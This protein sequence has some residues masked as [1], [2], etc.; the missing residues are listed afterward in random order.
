MSGSEL[1]EASIA[2][3]KLTGNCYWWLN[4]SNEN[5]PPDEIWFIQS[6]HIQPHPDER[7]YIDGYI[8][9]NP[10]DG[11]EIPLET[12]EIVHWKRFNPFNRFIG[13]SAIEALSVAITGDVEA[14]KWNTELFGKNNA[15]LPGILSF[16]TMHNPT[17]WEK[18]KNNVLAASEKRQLM[19]L[20]GVGEGGVD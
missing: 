15:R 13:L 20:N 18:I 1:S 19:M 11:T 17:D 16:K 3:Y 7:M 10:A 8:F 5:A 9:T 6:D 2:S 14:S 12:W 4:R